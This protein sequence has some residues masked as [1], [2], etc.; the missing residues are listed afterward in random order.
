ME[1]VRGDRP[2]GDATGS[3]GRVTVMNGWRP[4]VRQFT[5]LLGGR[6]PGQLVIQ[7]TDR[8]NATCPQCGMRVTERFDRT[9]LTMDEVRGIIDAAAEKGVRALSF[10]GGEPMLMIDDLAELIHYAGAAGIPYIRTGT[11]G[12]FFMHSHRSDFKSRIARIVDTLADTPLRNF[13]ISIDSAVPRVHETMRGFPRV[14][15][16]IR[17]ALPIFHAAGIYPSVNLGIN[18]NISK[19]TAGLSTMAGRPPH[20]EYLNAFYHRFREGFRE[21]YRFAVDMGFTLVNSCYPM[22]IDGE[23]DAGGNLSALYSASSAD[24]VVR[25]SREEK[26][27]LFRA[28]FDTIPEFRSEIRIFSPRVSV[29]ELWKQYSGCRKT[30]PYPCRGGMDFFFVNASD[31]NTYPCGYRGDENLGK[32]PD[33][34]L[35]SRKNGD[36]CLA[37]DWECFRDPSTFLGPIVEGLSR[38]ASLLRR[39]RSD[40]AYGAVWVEDLKYYRACDFFDGRTAPDY[41]RLGRF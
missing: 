12:F 14:I 5:G 16:G 6:V 26:G 18:R 10:T 13:W 7:L 20:E 17:S 37:C 1:I 11:N 21:F 28:L 4:A 31:G 36:R 3:K 24:H 34:D 22:S 35:A 15:D 25:F 30:F 2:L 39:L 33:L 32:F 29:Y 38:P 40:G 27:L 9:R 19:G 23:G 8:C 41:T